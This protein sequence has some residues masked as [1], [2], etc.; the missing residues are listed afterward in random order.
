MKPLI[1]FVCMGNIHRSAVAERSL[2]KA[3]VEA[4]LEEMYEVVSRGIMGFGTA[5]PPEGKNLRDYPDQYACNV[6]I[7]KELE[8]SLDD[9]I[10]TPIDEEIVRRASTVIA[11]DINV[12]VKD[13]NA[14]CRHFQDYL[15]K[16]HLFLEL[17]GET[18]GVED[19]GDHK[20]QDT[21]VRAVR[22]I[23]DTIVENVDTV[24]AW[25]K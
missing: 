4:G 24:L 12:F 14:L 21:H 6:E 13:P 18:S 17:I 23:H 15:P 22:T 19:C 7:L 5:P 10:A 1:L 2:R 11:M 25:V 8:L 20:D 9:H 3:L 16:I